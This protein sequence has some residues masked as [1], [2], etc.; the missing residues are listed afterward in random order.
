MD[1][2][3]ICRNLPRHRKR[4]KKK[5]RKIY[6][7]R[8]NCARSL[9]LIPH[10]PPAAP[11][12]TIIIISFHYH[13]QTPQNQTPHLNCSPQPSQLVSTPPLPFPS[14]PN[15]TETH[16]TRSSNSTL[17]P[18]LPPPISH[19]TPSP[20][21][22]TRATSPRS[23]TTVDQIIKHISTP[24]PS[25][26][27]QKNFDALSLVFTEKVIA[28]YSTPLGIPTPLSAV[29]EGLEGFLAPVEAQLAQETQI[30]EGINVCD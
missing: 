26:R 6:I 1:N 27:R 28:K 3:Y 10:L 7:L 11:F 2:L 23:A 29:K 30:V 15:P 20:Q 18:N 21:N 14:H 17:P 12:R 8:T 25:H 5:K 16:N 22:N 4:K 13:I 9:Y 19:H 24:S